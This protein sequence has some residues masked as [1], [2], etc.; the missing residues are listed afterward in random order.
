MKLTKIT[1]MAA[2]NATVAGRGAGAAASRVSGAMVSSSR[3]TGESASGA[4]DCPA[5]V[6]AWI[7]AT[8]TEAVLVK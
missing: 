3:N 6:P 5:Q 8:C 7:S 4:S 2:A 1:A